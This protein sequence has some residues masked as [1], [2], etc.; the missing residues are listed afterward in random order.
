LELV[1]NKVIKVVLTKKRCKSYAFIISADFEY[2]TFAVWCN[3]LGLE[4]ELAF[5]L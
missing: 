3:E 5:N 1:D 4:L 2:K